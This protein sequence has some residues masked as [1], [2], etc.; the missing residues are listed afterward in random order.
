MKT[1]LVIIIMLSYSVFSFISSAVT[2]V[3]VEGVIV[4]YDK[5]TVTLSQN[6]KKI[7]VPKKSI[8]HYFTI[9]SGNKV[10]AELDPKKTV[11]KIKEVIQQKK[12]E[13]KNRQ[14]KQ[15]KQLL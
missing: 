8:P 7:K 3:T 2:R 12:A 4:A 9:R 6:G 10:Y 14:D 5:K 1:I 13:N 11:K 15:R